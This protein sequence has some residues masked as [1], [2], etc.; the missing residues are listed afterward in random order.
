MSFERYYYI[1]FMELESKDYNFEIRESSNEVKQEE[2]DSFDL[3]LA[4]SGY[5]QVSDKSTY[6]HRVS[7]K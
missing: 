2:K 6:L 3:E 7:F 1:Y 5:L 4:M